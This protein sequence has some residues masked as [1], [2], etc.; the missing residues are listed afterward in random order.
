VFSIADGPDSDRQWDNLQ[1]HAS[2]LGLWS[3][4]GHVWGDYGESQHDI[5]MRTRR[6][7][8]KLREEFKP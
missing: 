4:D 2:R 6:G 3:D 5:I 7:L 1:K 8:E